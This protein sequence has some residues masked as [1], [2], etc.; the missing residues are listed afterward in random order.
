VYRELKR[1]HVTRM[2]AWQEYREH[3][4]EGYQYSQFATATGTG[5]SA[6]R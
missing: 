1:P 6:C 3:E 2:L 4:P 5:R